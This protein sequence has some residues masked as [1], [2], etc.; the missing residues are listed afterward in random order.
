MNLR[1]RRQQDPEVNIT[2]LIDVVFLLLIF[3]MITTTFKR[4]AE[5]Q[6][7]LPE[8]SATPVTTEIKRIEITINRDGQFFINEDKVINTKRE[9][10]TRALKSLVGD[11]TDI[12]VI[13]RADANS[14]MQATVT[15]MDVAGKLGLSK[16]SIATVQGEE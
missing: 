16:I 5:L 7:D 15:A 1:P 6:V 9:T 10:L 14:P 12:P 8:A 2:P 13:I 11:K 3:F 4:D